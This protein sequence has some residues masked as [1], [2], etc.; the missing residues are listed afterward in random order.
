MPS[1]F[2]IFECGNNLLNRL[3]VTYEQAGM[4]APINKYYEKMLKILVDY[5]DRNN[6]PFSSEK[7]QQAII[8]VM[9]ETEEEERNIISDS[10][11]VTMN[12]FCQSPITTN[13]QGDN[14]NVVCTSDWQNILDFL[15]ETLKGLTI[16]STS[17]ELAYYNSDKND[18]EGEK[19]DAE[20][21][22]K[23]DQLVATCTSGVKKIKVTDTDTTNRNSPQKLLI[24]QTLPM[25]ILPIDPRIAD[26]FVDGSGTTHAR[27]MPASKVINTDVSR[28]GAHVFRN[29]GDIIRT[30]RERTTPLNGNTSIRSPRFNSPVLIGGGTTAYPTR[31]EIQ[32]I[33]SPK[34]PT[35]PVEV[36]N[37]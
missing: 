16:D 12:T 14:T 34:G 19:N 29:P 6:A 36:R 9:A 8:T 21:D 27:Q 24:N 17:N 37:V 20:G 10:N 13:T 22:P 3:N 18:A 5:N 35:D 28:S 2:N 7:L 11:N 31:T 25:I 15:A 32:D 1:Y 30:D 23:I 33:I 4:A 26:R